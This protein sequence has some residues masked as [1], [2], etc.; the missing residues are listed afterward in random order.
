M[1][2]S[3]LRAQDILVKALKRFPSANELYG[4]WPTDPPLPNGSLQAALDNTRSLVLPAVEA[5]LASID[6]GVVIGDI[7]LTW[8]TGDAR[9]ANAA[10]IASEF[11]AAGYGKIHQIAALANAVAESNLNASSVNNT[12]PE[13]SVGLF[14]LNINNGVGSGHTEAELK[15]PA[16]NIELIL[17]KAKS[18]SEFKAAANLHDAVAVFVRKIEQPANQP[19]EIIKRLSFAQ[20][21]IA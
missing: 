4:G 6:E 12:P 16:K 9:R 2:P 19:G 8:I 1:R 20:K 14:Q 5:A 18:V 3:R 7:N 13:H 21:F 15:K 10:L 17:Q 11:A